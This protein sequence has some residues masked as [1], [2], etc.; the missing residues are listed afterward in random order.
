M[1]DRL[2]DRALKKMLRDT[3]GYT[4]LRAGQHEVIASVLKGNDTLAVMPT[5]AGK[6]LC[7]QLPALHLKGTRLQLSWRASA[8]QPRLLYDP[9]YVH[10][11]ASLRHCLVEGRNLVIMTGTGS[12]KTE[13][14]LNCLDAALA[15]GRGTLML[16]PEIALTP[17]VAG[18][19]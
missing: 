5:G 18:H 10:Q 2:Q 15:C 1:P 11:S 12:G 6:S 8:G 3:F 13:V 7:Y 14:Y 16:V 17:A 19:R 9:P 4:R